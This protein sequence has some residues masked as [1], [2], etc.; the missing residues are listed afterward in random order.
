MKK[1]VLKKDVVAR[2]NSGEM[3][4][5]KGGAGTWEDTCANG[6][7][8]PKTGPQDPTCQ[9][10]CNKEQTCPDYQTCQDNSCRPTCYY[11]CAGQYSCVASC[12]VYCQTNLGCGY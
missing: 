7:E 1:L 9:N 5:L 11:T 4:Q 10:T 2:I 12:D 3:N 8:K 6:C